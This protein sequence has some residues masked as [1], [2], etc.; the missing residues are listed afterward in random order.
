MT[1]DWFAAGF[2]EMSRLP[3]Q[4]WR[5]PRPGLWITASAIFLDWQF[6]PKPPPSGTAVLAV[7]TMLGNA[8]RRSRTSRPAWTE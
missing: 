6:T 2:G 8:G 7:I 3:W 1:T 5:I 4:P